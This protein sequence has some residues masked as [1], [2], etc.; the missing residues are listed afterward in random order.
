MTVR[1][2]RG[3]TVAVSCGAALGLTACS[4]FA[5]YDGFG[6]PADPPTTEDGGAAD[7]PAVDGA[8]VDGA[9]DAGLRDSVGEPLDDA[10]VDVLRSCAAPGLFA[11]FSF[12]QADAGV[13]PS[14]GSAQLYGV[15]QPPAGSITTAHQGL[16]FDTDGTRAVEIR[17]LVGDPF[18]S[19]GGEVTILAW[20]RPSSLAFGD[21]LGSIIDKSGDKSAA[22]LGWGLRVNA[23]GG[24]VLATSNPANDESTSYASSAGAVKSGQPSYVAARF[25]R[26]DIT[27]FVD[28]TAV[29]TAKATVN[30]LFSEPKVK[31]LIG[32]R[33][34]ADVLND[35]PFEGFI[36]D[37]RIF[38][39]A[40]TDNEIAT[41]AK[42]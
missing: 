27:L 37:V 2:R 24:I 8:P 39:R 10:Q 17:P 7:A 4:L 15:L 31:A 5:N 9:T 26:G 6:R 22:E 33:P 19:L 28:G 35:F 3:R 41:L 36:D 25:D 34:I 11:F 30:Q 32:R 29:G 16:A 42:N 21:G 38:A 13:V 12:E 18:A 40:L 14:C 1:I 23:A 20:I